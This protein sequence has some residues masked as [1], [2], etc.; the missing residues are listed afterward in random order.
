MSGNV[1]GSDGGSDELGRDMELASAL[2][3]VDPA[4]GDPNYWLRFQSWV[5]ARAGHELARRRMMA[6][7]TIGEVLSGW[8]RAVVPTAVVAA[9]VAGFV[10]LRT[11]PVSVPARVTVE[12]LLLVGLE[13]QTIPATLTNDEDAAAEA[14]AFAGERF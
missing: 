7:L 12:D 2:A 6:D 8:A 5:M 11:T 10:L 9:I 3:F 14:V 4:T 1:Q 13:D